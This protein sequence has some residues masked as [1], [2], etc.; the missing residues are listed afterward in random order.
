MQAKTMAAVGGVV[1]AGVAAAWVG[2]GVWIGQRLEGELQAW[3]AQPAGPGTAVRL[4]GLQ[5]QRGL[6]SS[7]GQA[8]VRLEPGCDAA[9]GQ[10][11]PLTLTL[12]YRASHLPWPTSVVR[13][14]WQLRPAGETAREF[15]QVF[16]D[17]AQLSGH[18]SV[19]AGGA[20]RTEMSVP[21][22]SVRRAGSA[23]RVAASSGT[24][25][26]D[27]K[28]VGFGWRWPQVTARGDGQAV[29]MKDVALDMDLSNRFLGTGQAQLSVATLSTGLGQVDGM[30]LR[31]EARENGDRLD[32]SLRPAVARIVAGGQTVE[33]LALELHV[34]GLDTRSVETLTTTF[35]AS[36]GLQALTADEAGRV[37][38]AVL[39]LLT[40][41]FSAGIGQLTGRSRE[42]AIDGEWRVELTPARGAHIRLAEQLRSSGRLDLG[43][44]LLTDEQRQTLLAMG[45][46][47]E[48]AGGLRAS[49]DY[50]DGLLKVN[51]R[52]LD[53]G[54]F[55][56]T[57]AEAD[58]RLSEQ[59]AEW[60]APR[61][62]QARSTAPA[63][64]V[65]AP[66]PGAGH[67]DRHRVH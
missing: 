21:A 10:D 54:G 46:A 2:A 43:A 1:V 49:Y 36:C 4:T 14:D 22:L 28:A 35:S 13:F 17:A 6:L 52:T 53:A 3:Q 44:G 48:Q 62:T 26:V 47:L 55:Q 33:G 45:V 8:T 66:E 50:A 34:K 32:M 41:G 7:S 65:E 20:L 19:S 39:T 30:T 63:A 16:G 40:R 12:N 58:Q 5:H 23:L 9:E 67:A 31:T 27:G 37:R 38:E 18:G 56:Q 59:M 64:P 60:S 51:G 57:L 11:E 42:G 15:A 25:S 61:V 24:L 29:E